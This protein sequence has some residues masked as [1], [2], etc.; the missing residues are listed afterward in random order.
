MAPTKVS[1]FPELLKI[2]AMLATP[3]L[4]IPV[5]GLSLR[6]NMAV[7]SPVTSHPSYCGSSGECHLTPMTSDPSPDR[8]AIKWLHLII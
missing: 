7:N 6:L 4:L 3:V 8:A 2:G 1:F 5:A